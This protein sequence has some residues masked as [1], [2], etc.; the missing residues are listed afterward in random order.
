MSRSVTSQPQ[1]E[2]P[3]NLRACCDEL[4]ALGRELVELGGDPRR[5]TY[6]S[7][8]LFEIDHP[9]TV[10]AGNGVFLYKPSNDLLETLAAMRAE[11][12]NLK[13]IKVIHAARRGLG[14]C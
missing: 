3:D 9:A 10:Q 2:S 7:M 13:N 4:V 6:R 1:R 11:K 14:H 5:F 8:V 12:I